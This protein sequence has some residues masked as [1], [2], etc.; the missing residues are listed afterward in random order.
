MNELFAYSRR[1]AFSDTDAMGVTHHAN[2]LRF[3]EEARVA[4]MRERGLTA[5]HYPHCELVLALVHYQVWHLRTSTFEDLL[6][7]QLQVRREGLKI[8]FQYAIYKEE[9]KI[10]EAETLH[11]TMNLQLAATRPHKDLLTVLENE[12]WTETWLSNLSAS[13]KPQL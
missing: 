6:K 10:A 1:V 8:R 7:I 3:C 9:V 11:V 5:M 12:L 13:P 2:Y 4:W